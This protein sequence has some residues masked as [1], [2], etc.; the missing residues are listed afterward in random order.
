MCIRIVEATFHRSNHVE[1]TPVPETWGVMDAGKEESCTYSPATAMPL[2]HSVHFGIIA[3][4][5]YMDYKKR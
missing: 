5:R 3:V 1:S 2:D 4:N